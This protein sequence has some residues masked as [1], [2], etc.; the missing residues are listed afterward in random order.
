M[1]LLLWEFSC[2]VSHHL[3]KGT[4]VQKT[5][6]DR[7]FLGDLIGSKCGTGVVGTRNNSQNRVAVEYFEPGNPT[8]LS[9]HFYARATAFK[10]L[11]PVLQKCWAIQMK[12][13]P[14]TNLIRKE[15][16]RKT[17]EA[18]QIIRFLAWKRK[19]DS[20][21]N[22]LQQHKIDSPSLGQ[23]ELNHLEIE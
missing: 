16:G 3:R 7:A 14:V 15:G 9:G 1:V 22:L 21:E 19:C 5:S 13:Q 8:P 11:Q 6:N 23:I 12:Q 10:C 18:L 20:R 2:V 4:K 17:R